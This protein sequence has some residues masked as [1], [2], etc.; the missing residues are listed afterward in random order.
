MV[1]PAPRSMNHDLEAGMSDG[2]YRKIVANRGGIVE[3][4]A[5]VA[6]RRDLYDVW[7]GMHEAPVKVLPDATVDRNSIGY[8]PT[9]QAQIGI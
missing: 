1:Y 3:A 8:V 5:T 2:K 6:A 4:D 7:Y 9:P